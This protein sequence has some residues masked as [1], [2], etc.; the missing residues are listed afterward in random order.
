MLAAANGPLDDV[1]RVIVTVYGRV[2]WRVRSEDERA[3]LDLRAV[4]RA[5]RSG[6]VQDAEMVSD[7]LFFKNKKKIWNI[8]IIFI[9]LKQEKNTIYFLHVDL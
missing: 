9:S 4:A 6:A 5:D 7:K 8:I 2:I 3:G 1:S